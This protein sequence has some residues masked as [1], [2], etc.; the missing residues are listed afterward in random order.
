MHWLPQADLQGAGTPGL[1]SSCLQPPTLGELSWAGPKTVPFLAAAVWAVLSRGAGPVPRS[2]MG[3]LG[4]A[5]RTK[6]QPTERARLP[7][8]GPV[9]PHGS[10]ILSPP[11]RNTVAYVLP[12]PGFLFHSSHLLKHHLLLEG[13]PDRLFGNVPLLCYWS[14]PS[15]SHS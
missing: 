11:P 8:M 15:R 2:K 3:C 14:L 4:P 1:L 10:R 9:Y 12:H 13:L 6:Q 7:V 5:G